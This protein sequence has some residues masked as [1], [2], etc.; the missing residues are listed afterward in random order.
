MDA[1]VILKNLL[2]T[3]FRSDVLEMWQIYEKHSGNICVKLRFNGRQ[4]DQDVNSLHNNTRSG[5]FK[6]RSETQ[7][8]PGHSPS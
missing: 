5:T 1:P 6:R 3:L 8:G 7:S 4:S 2:G